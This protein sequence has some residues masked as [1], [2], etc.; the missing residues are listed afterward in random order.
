METKK[1]E[2]KKEWKTPELIILVRSKPEE[3]VLLPECRVG[4]HGGYTDLD[5]NC[6]VKPCSICYIMPRT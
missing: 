1:V 6:K 3:A 4:V 5:A 2:T